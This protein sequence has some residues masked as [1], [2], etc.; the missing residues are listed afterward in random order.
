[1]ALVTAK[2]LE[3]SEIPV[4]LFVAL[5]GQDPGMAASCDRRQY[6]EPGIAVLGIQ[7]WR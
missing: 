7:E 5:P 4:D 6:D 3:A 2:K 1:M